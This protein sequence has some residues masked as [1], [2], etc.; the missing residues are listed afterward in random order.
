MSEQTI[1]ENTLNAISL[2]VLADGQL[3]SGKQDGQTIDLF[4]QLPPLASL[5]A[6]EALYGK[7]EKRNKMSVTCG[8]MLLGSKESLDLQAYLESRLRKLLPLA[9][10]TMSFMIWK[11]MVTPAGRQLLR[12]VPS[13]QWMRENGFTLLPR[14]T[15]Q[16]GRDWSRAEVLARLDRG[17]RVARRICK[18]SANLRSS[19]EIVGL[20]PYFAGW[21]MGYPAEHISCVFTAMQSIPCS[22]RNSSKQQCEQRSRESD[23]GN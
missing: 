23:N 6:K 15:A 17:G 8:L 1:S 2:P 13:K 9:G 18:R 22:R 19:Q 5:T 11:K 12:L 10:W 20:H 16:E 21:M 3:H 14:L 4:G 7:K